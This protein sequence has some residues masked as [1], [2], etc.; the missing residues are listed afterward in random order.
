MVSSGH[1]QSKTGFL[2][3]K[4]FILFLCFTRLGST[5][6]GDPRAT[7]NPGSPSSSPHTPSALGSGISDPVL[8][9][10]LC[11][12][13]YCS[14][15]GG[16]SAQT[17]RC[18]AFPQPGNQLPQRTTWKCVFEMVKRFD[19]TAVSERHHFRKMFDLCRLSHDA[20]SLT[21][22]HLIPFQ[23]LIYAFML[24]LLFLPVTTRCPNRT[25]SKGKQDCE[26]RKGNLLCLHAL[27][28]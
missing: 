24:F 28:L 10:G 21:Y 16:R 9:G 13:A 11:S 3:L 18:F 17:G 6:A 27:K 26:K 15:A 19:S 25:Q 20:Y 12:A 14:S 7:S 23:C 4:E 22:S 1:N 8:N 2:H 5:H